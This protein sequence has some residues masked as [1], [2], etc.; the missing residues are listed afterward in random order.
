MGRT[1]TYNN[2]AGLNKALR[3]LPKEAS[4]ELRDASQRLAGDIAGKASVR[5]RTVGGVAKYV[6]PTI[7]ARRD[8]VPVVVMGGTSRL[9]TSGGDWSRPRS[10]SG[11]TV[12]DVVWGAEFG[13][14]RFRQFSPWRGNDEGA[15][16]FL[17]PTIRADNDHI[18]DEYSG[19][20]AD[21]LR[22][23]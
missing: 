2:I 7:K 21:A 16:Y 4:A 20:L 11:Q 12:G 5:A 22:R 15:G 10:G 17:W 8:R 23:I 1:T 9:P 18:M 6:A 3:R 19:A 14:D 13:S